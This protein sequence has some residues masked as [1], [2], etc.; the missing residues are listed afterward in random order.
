M[1]LNIYAFPVQS[2][3]FQVIDPEKLGEDDRAAEMSCWYDNVANTAFEIK[4]K[5]DITSIY[6]V[7]PKDFISRIQDIVSGVFGMIV[8]WI[9]TMNNVLK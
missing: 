5:Y 1:I 6:I 3:T 2:I 9:P 8:E 7:G 4:N